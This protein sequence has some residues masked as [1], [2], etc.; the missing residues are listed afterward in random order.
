[1]PFLVE[2]LR[3]Q[4]QALQIDSSALAFTAEEVEVLL[5]DLGP[6]AAALAG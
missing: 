3:G 5:L 1:M 2:R 4:G 6:D